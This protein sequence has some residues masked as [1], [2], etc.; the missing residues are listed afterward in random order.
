MRYRLTND[1]TLNSRALIL[2]YTSRN[3]ESTARSQKSG[4]HSRRNLDKKVSMI[5]I[6]EATDIIDLGYGFTGEF[7]FVSKPKLASRMV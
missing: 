3:P 1:S 6:L 7:Y 4:I 5:T 2:K